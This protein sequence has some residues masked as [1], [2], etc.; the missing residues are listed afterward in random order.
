M[1]SGNTS[2]LF[3]VP[4]SLSF[5]EASGIIVGNLKLAREHILSVRTA[6]ECYII[7]YEIML[8]AVFRFCTLAFVVLCFMCIIGLDTTNPYIYGERCFELHTD[9]KSEFLVPCWFVIWGFSLVFEVMKLEKELLK[10]LEIK[11]F[12]L[13]WL[14][15]IFSQAWFS[16]NLIKSLK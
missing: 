12:T 4:P 13:F 11:W 10:S 6:G 15:L 1:L 3:L 16:I 8:Y 5:S 2:S 14:K 9:S 7:S